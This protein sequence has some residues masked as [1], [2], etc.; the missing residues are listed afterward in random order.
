M[1][2]FEGN[3]EQ[4]ADD[5]LNHFFVDPFKYH[6]M[7][8]EADAVNKANF[9]EEFKVYQEGD[10]LTKKSPAVTFGK[11]G[12]R[13]PHNGIAVEESPSFPITASHQDLNTPQA[14]T[15]QLI[16]DLDL[17][18]INPAAN[19]TGSELLK[20]VVAERDNHYFSLTDDGKADNNANFLYPPLNAT[21]NL[22]NQDEEDFLQNM[23]EQYKRDIGGHFISEAR[24]E[25]FARQVIPKEK[26]QE[27][28]KM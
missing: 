26:L 22:L 16:S 15:Q 9:F 17:T 3:S 19:I 8:K 1:R 12:K 28:M 10:N 20:E 4:Q 11:G 18:Q 7:A 23:L 13:P 25:T 6:Q 2:K 5:F 27:I 21:N 14:E 24:I